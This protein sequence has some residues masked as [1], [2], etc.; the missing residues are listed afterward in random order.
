MELT[1]REATT[2]ALSPVTRIDTGKGI[3][4]GVRLLGPKS[5]NG[6]LYTQA[7]RQDAFEKVESV[8]CYIDHPPGESNERS[9][10]ERF[11]RFVG[12]YYDADGTLCAKE[13]HYNPQHEFASDFVWLTENA[14]DDIG[15][16][17]N[18]RA[19][20]KRLPS[21]EMECTRLPKVYSFDLV[22]SPAT[23]A[24][25]FASVRESVQYRKESLTQPVR[26]STM[27]GQ[28]FD[29]G[30]VEFGA[31]LK[32]GELDK[33]GAVK[34]LKTLLTLLGDQPSAE[35]TTPDTAG[36]SMDAAIDAAPE[37]EKEVK[38][39]EQAKQ[40]GRK[41]AGILVGSLEKLK[42]DLDTFQVR[43]R[44]RTEA[45]AKAKRDG[46]RLAKASTKLPADVITVVFREQVCSA[47]D[48]AAV[49]A[50]IADR[51]ALVVSAKTT[52]VRESAV[53]APAPTN[54]GKPFDAKEVA[55]KLF[56]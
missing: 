34:A 32:S 42:A 8:G 52:A 1:V 22:D 50:L 25:L 28:A 53:T 31:K 5:V 10:R 37:P 46:D 54:T 47:A 16:S 18:A 43:E 36:A 38:A 27:F 56:G 30:M 35:T 41:F 19:I 48:D 20:P 44:T 51:A 33:A 14:R 17:V 21:G 45:E 7:A 23:T 11:G 49:D 24:G 3:V 26:E 12:P 13:F 4:Y 55:A 2:H 29:A 9:V 6:R 40:S 39:M 15:F